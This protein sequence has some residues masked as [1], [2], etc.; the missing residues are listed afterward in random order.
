MKRLFLLGHLLLLAAC[1]APHAPNT[2]PQTQ[3]HHPKMRHTI[4]SQYDFAT[5]VSRLSQAIQS[6]GMT[7]FATINHTAAAQQAGLSLQP[8]TV[9]VYGN[10]KAGTPLMQKDPALA[11]Q[12]PLRVLITEVDGKVQVIYP[13]TRA[14]IHGSQIAYSEVENTL[15]NAEKLIRATVSAQK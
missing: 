3:A 11:L 1:A 4:E 13:D 8:A 9:L 10:P 7:I 2:A 12:L 14:V 15:A 5:T 6:K